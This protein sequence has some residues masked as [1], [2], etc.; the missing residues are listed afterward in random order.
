M[1]IFLETI[2]DHQL[3]KLPKIIVSNYCVFSKY[4]PNHMLNEMNR[5]S[6]MLTDLDKR[7]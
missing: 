1:L 3:L 6:L 5:E 4:L 2:E 7:Q